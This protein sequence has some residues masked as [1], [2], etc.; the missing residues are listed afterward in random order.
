MMLWPIPF[1]ESEHA[2]GEPARAGH[3]TVGVPATPE[4][5]RAPGS[6]NKRGEAVYRQPRPGGEVWSKVEQ[7]DDDGDHH[8]RW[9]V[10][11]ENGIDP[12]LE[13]SVCGKRRGRPAA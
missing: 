3:E 4:I 7:S 13:R 9:G 11:D 2:K 10:P 5:E 1:G 8:H 12:L 6:T